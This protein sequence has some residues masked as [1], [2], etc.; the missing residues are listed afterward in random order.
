MERRLQF[1]L[2]PHARSQCGSGDI[3]KAL[4]D[5]CNRYW[6][7]ANQATKVEQSVVGIQNVTHMS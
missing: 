3:P 5:G 2:P 4:V 7:V 6:T 1:F